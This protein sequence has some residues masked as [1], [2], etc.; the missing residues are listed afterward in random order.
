MKKRRA[1]ALLLFLLLLAGIVALPPIRIR[2]VGLIRGES[3]F[4]GLPTTYWREQALVHDRV[5]WEW[6]RQGK[7]GLVPPPPPWTDLLASLFLSG[8]Q[9]EQPDFRIL[10]GDFAALAVLLELLEDPERAVRE[11]TCEGL[12][13]IGPAAAPAV[14]SLVELLTG[15]ELALQEPA[16]EALVSIGAPAVPAL[17]EKLRE[18]GPRTADVID[19]LGSIG[20]AAAPAIPALQQALNKYPRA[21]GALAG[22]GPKA[23]PVLLQAVASHDSEV[24]SAVALNLPEAGGDPA[25]VLPVLVRLLKDENKYV[26]RNAAWA[27]GEFKEAGI[28]G[29]IEA[30]KSPDPEVV[31]EAVS[32]L[33]WTPAPV[34]R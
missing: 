20:P 34:P 24:R 26:R 10:S 23:F 12:A 21:V 27:L 2:L 17:L 25:I 6:T 3:F 5:R 7:Y 14:P 9:E 13:K 33:H 1:I 16:Q 22:I 29:L 18:D 19:T 8:A 31:R 28:P 15:E 32:G 30:L 4:E 11:S